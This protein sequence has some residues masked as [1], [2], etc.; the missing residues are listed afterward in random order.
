MRLVPADLVTADFGSALVEYAAV[1]ADRIGACKLQG[2]KR[3]AKRT[4]DRTTDRRPN[5]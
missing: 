1:T 2:D 3:S 5:L 4:H